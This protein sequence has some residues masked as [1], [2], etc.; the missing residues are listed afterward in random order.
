MSTILVNANI[1]VERGNFQEAML[2]ENGIIKAVGTNAE[3]RALAPAGCEEID[4][5][6]R[7]VIPGFNDS[8]QHLYN[9]GESLRMIKLHEVPSPVSYTHL[10]LSPD[11]SES[12]GSGT[13]SL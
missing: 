5:E 10:S 13:A 7:T 1:Y 6:G 12:G 3:I 2:I 8:H 11:P 4:A 9:V